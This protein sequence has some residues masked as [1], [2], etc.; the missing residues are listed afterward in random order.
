MRVFYI[1][2]V[3]ILFSFSGCMLSKTELEY[4]LNIPQNFTKNIDK[5]TKT[6]RFWYKEFNSDELN[7]LI[8]IGLKNS[9][10]LLSAYEKI[11]Q[12]KLLVD[13]ADV[14]YKPKVDLSASSSKR[15]NIDSNH[16]KTRPE[17]TSLG[18]SMSYEVDIW[19]K[20][21]ASIDSAK[22]NLNFN[23]YDFDA[24]KLSLI[25]NITTTYFEYLSLAQKQTIAK[26]N[27]TIAKQIFDITQSKY[28]NGIIDK[29]DINR[30]KQLLLQSESSL[31]TLK[32]QK[33]LKLNALAL[34]VGL[35]SSEL[36]IKTA[37]LD[38]I[39]TI[40]VNS[41]LPSELLLS[42]PDI[43]AALESLESARA[44][45]DI[46]RA[47]KLPSFS[48]SGDGGVSS[49]KLLS[50]SNL[51]STL[52][53]GIRINYNL[54]DDGELENKILIEKSKAKALVQNYKNSILNAFKEVNDALLSTS[55][56]KDELVLYEQMLDES[57]S[58]YEISKLKY[59]N[60]LSDLNTMLDTQKS[61]F[62]SKESMISQ[63]LS[64]LVNLVVLTKSLGGGWSK[65]DEF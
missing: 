7:S 15:L 50:L 39:K 8:D 46:A 23:Q 10:T 2:V 53:L 52:G 55:L 4:E 44:S 24:M 25:S 59:E 38:A 62:N 49:V 58:A 22:A 43:A 17:S 41:T 19:G 21:R 48:L 13:I 5:P 12:A 60:G 28:N 42:R 33:E 32:T 6:D 14:A 1:L 31:N 57:K 16:N 3:P 65:E 61:Y 37:D 56:D 40:N 35:N 45:I 63:K 20:T 47:A 18:A 54:F 34:L 29:L 30:Q 27:Y 51:T 36:D 26:E 9:P 64:Y 11:E